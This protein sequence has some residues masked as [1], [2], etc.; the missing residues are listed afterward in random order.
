M[1]AKVAAELN[2][3][4]YPAETYRNPGQTAFGREVRSL[5]KYRKDIKLD[6]LTEQIL[7]S[8]D[9]SSTE[10]EVVT[11]GVAAGKIMI[12]D[13]HNCVS[14]LMYGVA[15]K[16]KFE[17]LDSIYLLASKMT[18]MHLFVLNA[19]YEVLKSRHH[20]DIV[21]GKQV[22][23]KFQ[24]RGDEYHQ[25]VK[26]YYDCLTAWAYDVELI[27]N[28]NH[29]VDMPAISPDLIDDYSR[30]SKR[31]EKVLAV[32]KQHIYSIYN[33]NVDRE[34]DKIVDEI[35]TKIVGL[36]SSV[37]SCPTQSSGS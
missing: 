15:G 12:A 35:T 14:G 11:P 25:K 10:H 26:H 9:M 34:L 20:H 2:N 29:P 37:S 33:V 18:K 31:I 16:L 27:R 17:D 7:M 3:R 4:G 5:V 22:E 30:V 28:G 19:P 32:D 8:A 21:D 13:R 36:I 23:C 1:V 24:L 6:P